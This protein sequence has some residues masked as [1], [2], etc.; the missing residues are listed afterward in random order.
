MKTT[1]KQPNLSNIT[2]K[3]VELLSPYS[4]DYSARLSASELSRK[5]SIPQQTI[6][7]YLND[8]AALNII[9]YSKEGRNKLF[10]LDLE[11]QTTRIMLNLI[12]N[13]KAL[14]FQMK[15]KETAIIVNS[16]LKHCEGLVIFGSY[17][18]GK[19]KKGSDLDILIMG[20]HDKAKIKSIKRAQIIDVNEHYTSYADF[21]KTIN[22]RNP[23]SMEIMKNHILFGDVSRIINIFWR[24]EYER[25]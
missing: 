11:R 15:E 23:L 7:R 19:Q 4:T 14:Q 9:N 18:S 1:K 8:L 25:R 3:W 24:Q 21:T 20:R 10:Y 12:E 17:A 5:A 13:Q 16:M 6:S 22:S 2:Q